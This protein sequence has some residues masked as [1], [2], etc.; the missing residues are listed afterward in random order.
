[1]RHVEGIVYELIKNTS[2][3]QPGERSVASLEKQYREIYSGSY[4]RRNKRGGLVELEFI[5]EK[6]PAQEGDFGGPYAK[7]SLGGRRGRGGMSESVHLVWQ[8]LV[9]VEGL[10]W[11]QP[12]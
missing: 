12:F 8:D 4:S 1:M 5:D 7:V 2:Y 11:C 10:V 3:A 6:P 9:N